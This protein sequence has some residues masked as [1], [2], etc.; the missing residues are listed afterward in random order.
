MKIMIYRILGNDLPP[1]HQIGQTYKNTHFLL[2]Y[3]PELLHCRRK[4]VVNRIVDP[5]YERKLISLLERY[6]QSYVH[7]PFSLKE[8]KA[9]WDKPISDKVVSGQLSTSEDRVLHNQLLYITNVN[10]ARNL[11]LE[12]WKK[13]ADWVLPLDG[14]CYFTSEGWQGIVQRLE[15]ESSFD[16]YFLVPMYRLTT[17]EQALNFKVSN[18]TEHEPQI[19]FGKHTRLEFNSQCRYGL[20]DKVELIRRIG[21]ALEYNGNCFRPVDSR[22]NC[23]FV[24]RLFSGVAV[25]ENNIVDRARLRDQGIDNI[26]RTLDKQS[27]Y[28]ILGE[29]KRILARWL[30]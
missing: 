15:G 30:K 5:V 24:L 7:I 25:A 8:Y 9:C 14:N 21:F 2:T 1:R 29:A 6:G 20:E 26:L 22:D 10:Y 28:K 13:E 11:A 4:W 3:E 18:Q 27:I 17:N 12:Y 23:G 19:I 16:K